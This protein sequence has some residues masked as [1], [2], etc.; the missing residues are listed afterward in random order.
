MTDFWLISVPGNP[1]PNKSWEEIAE[2]TAHLSSSSKF[3]IPDLKVR[4]LPVRS[5]IC[6]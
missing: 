2:K 5:V 1:T 4:L 3:S 6:M